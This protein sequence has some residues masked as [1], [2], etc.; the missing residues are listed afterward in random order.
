MIRVLIVDDHPVVRWGLRQML[1]TD[2]DIEIVGE[3]EDGKAL[4][5]KVGDIRPDVILLDIRMPGLSGMQAVEGIRERSPG[6]RILISTVFDDVDHSHQALAAGVDGYLLKTASRDELVN[7][8]RSVMDGRRVVDAGLMHLVLNR[9][10]ELAR[11][12]DQERSVLTPEEQH[13][14]RLLSSGATVSGI[15]RELHMSVATV[16]RRINQVCEKLGVENRAQVVR[17]ATRHGLV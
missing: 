17:E 7:A 6:S 16:G 15:A 1:A 2:L 9:F 13:L 11:G 12:R 3:I 5:D 10:V 4:L 8:I 14:I